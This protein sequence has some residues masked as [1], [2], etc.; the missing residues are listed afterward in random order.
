[1]IILLVLFGLMLGYDWIRNGNLSSLLM[2][3]IAGGICAAVLS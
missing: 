1:M 2:T 3:L